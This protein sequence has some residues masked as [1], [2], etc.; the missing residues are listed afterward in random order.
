[1]DQQELVISSD[2]ANL[3]GVLDFVRSRC[4]AAGMS[5]DA[6]FACELA[7]DEACTNVI[8]HAYRD[9]QG[10]PI[11]ISCHLN[12]DHFVVQLH[13]HGRPFDPT[14]VAAPTLSGSLSERDIGGLGLHFMRSLMDE[15]RFEFDAEAGNT[16]TMVKRID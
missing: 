1:M 8:E 2:L 4:I 15:V 6:V 5:E 16:L 11:R 7:T 12:G 14:Q 9:S 13:D 3:P 10:G